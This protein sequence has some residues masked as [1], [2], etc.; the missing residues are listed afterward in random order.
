MLQIVFDLALSGAKKIVSIADELL[1]KA[2]K[3][4]G[5]GQKVEFPE[6]AFY[7]PMAYALLGH[8]VKTLN[9]ISVPLNEAKSLIKLETSVNSRLARLGVLES[10]LS[11]LL[12]AEIITGIKYLYKQEPQPDCEGFFP[13]T[14]LRTLGIQ[15]V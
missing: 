4:K 9:D 8:E 3:E 14:I 1:V 13:D 2:V 10:G 7:F 11:A 12:G 5:P 15:L 6:T